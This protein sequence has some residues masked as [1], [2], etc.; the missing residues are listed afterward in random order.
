[1][2]KSADTVVVTG[3][4]QAIQL[5]RATWAFL[6][7]YEWTPSFV[8]FTTYFDSYSLPACG[9]TKYRLLKTPLTMFKE[10]YG[11]AS[12]KTGI[13]R[14]MGWKCAGRLD[15]TCSTH[16][17]HSACFGFKPCPGYTYEGLSYLSQNLQT[18][19][20][21]SQDSFLPT[22][23]PIYCS[24]TIR[25]YSVW[26]ADSSINLYTHTHIYIYIYIYIYI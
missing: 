21:L 26:D 16:S 7:S 13:Y 20:N 1:M 8:G 23:Y 17:S 25:Q 24:R 6:F 10:K 14:K 11:M 3:R 22:T 19:S 4:K 9:Q 15:R 18:K 12:C 5:G 2:S